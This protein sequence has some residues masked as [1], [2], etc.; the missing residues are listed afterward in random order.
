MKRIHISAPTSDHSVFSQAF[1]LIE[2]LVVVAIIAV[3]ASMILGVAGLATKKADEGKAL[4][5][6]EKIKNALEDYRVE[7][8][9]YPINFLPANTTNWVAQL[10]CQPQA[11]GKKP[12]LVLKGWTDPNINYGAIDP[13]GATYRYLHRSASPYADHNDSKFGYDLWSLG[14]D[15]QTNLNNWTAQ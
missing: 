6:M 13:W 4:S 3:L 12:F 14:P 15:G 9:R 7:Y 5:D 8:G 10:W 1:T 2:V 11:L